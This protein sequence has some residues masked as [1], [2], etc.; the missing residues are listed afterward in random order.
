MGLSKMFRPSTSK[1]RLALMASLA[2][3]PGI[4]RAAGYEVLEQ[5]AIAQGTSYAGASARAD[6]ASLMYYNPAGITR[7]SGVQISGGIS[8]IFPTV[9]QTGGAAATGGYLNSTPYSGI[10]GGNSAASAGAPNFT[11]TGQVSPTVFLGFSLTS[12]Y[13]LVTKYGPN[14]IDRYYATT[15]AL[16]TINLGPAAAW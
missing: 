14:S 15:T 5:S 3:S 9:T 7:L 8:G 11:V 13:G 12:P 2:A 4:A 10:F 1:L 16:Q 6:D